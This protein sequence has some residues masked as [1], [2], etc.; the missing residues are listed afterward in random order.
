MSPRSYVHGCLFL[1]TKI[2]GWVEQIETQRPQK[3]VFVYCW[4]SFHST[5]PTD[6]DSEWWMV[7]GR[8]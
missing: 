3:S 2:V 5:Q 6:L 7:N 1:L 4:V 8:S